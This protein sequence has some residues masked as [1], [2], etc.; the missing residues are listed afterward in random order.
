[1]IAVTRLNSLAHAL[2]NG[3]RRQAMRASIN[4]FHCPS[5]T[6]PDT[7]TATQRKPAHEN[8]SAQTAVALSNYLACNSSGHLRNNDGRADGNANG[9]FMRN[10]E[11]RMADITDGTSNTIAVGERAWEARRNG[12][13]R[14]RAGIVFGALG[15]QANSNDGIA[16]CLAS[17]HQKINLFGE[18]R[19]SFNS[20]HP[21]GAQF[22]FADGS[23]HFI[24]QTV[25]H[26]TNAAVNSLIERLAC[27]NDGDVV[28]LPK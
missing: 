16:S 13:H 22:V 17:M 28:E 8:S 7:N 26:N 23:V 9:I 18:C 25:H 27:R 15:N 12:L 20:I 10:K 21:G 3:S 1:M 5:D 14:C 24:S 2:N 6:G 4:T 19:R 11:F